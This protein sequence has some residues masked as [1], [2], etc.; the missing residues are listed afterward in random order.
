[1]DE[2][3]KRFEFS[4]WR[5]PILFACMVVVLAVASKGVFLQK[6]NILNLFSQN[7]VIGI[8]A[9]GQFIVILS[10]GIDLSV[11]SLLSFTTVLYVYNQQI[12]VLPSV[13]ITLA[14]GIGIGA[15]NGIL[16]TK[17]KITPFITTLATMEVIRGA[18]NIMVNGHIIY[19]IKPEFLKLG[20][21]KLFGISAVVYI[22]IA[23][24][25]AFILLLK[26]TAT[27]V[28][29]YSIGGNERTSLL[30]GLN[31]DKYK[32]VAYML[33]GV[34]T[35]IAGILYTTRLQLGSPNVGASFSMDAITA[36]VIGG[37]ALTG[38]EGKLLN[39]MLGVLIL[40][41]L[42]N[43]MN[44]I[45]IPSEMHVGIKGAILVITVFLNNSTTFHEWNL[46]RKAG[47]SL[48]GGPKKSL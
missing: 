44:I 13:L 18:V 42:N 11:G 48:P 34:L 32:I 1:M 35:A 27:G 43:F 7:A 8:I 28:S 46:K 39:A 9:I 14:A 17:F 6:N 33:S 24:A 21:I 19:D 23:L 47:R 31:T 40:G 22:W 2:K 38:G 20:E 12:G 30:S 10:G 15:L 4:D 16:V 5:M 37:A 26:Y 3:K 25:V 45:G 36:V 41:M 29:F